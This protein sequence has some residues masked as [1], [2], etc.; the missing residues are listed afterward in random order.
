MGALSKHPRP[1]QE[2]RVALVG[3]FAKTGTPPLEREL[4]GPERR[5][6]PIDEEQLSLAP[7]DDGVD[8]KKRLH[9]QV[10]REELASAHD[11]D[12]GAFV[13]GIRVKPQPL[14]CVLERRLRCRLE[15][16][17]ARH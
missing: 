12:P 10:G 3:A 5:A 8:L 4:D 17:A 13:V 9:V 14:E 1:L 7:V 15:T 2:N 6:I 11:V 16:G